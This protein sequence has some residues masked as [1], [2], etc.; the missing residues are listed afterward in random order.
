MHATFLQ[1]VG[2]TIIAAL[3]AAG[4]VECWKFT[5]RANDEINSPNSWQQGGSHF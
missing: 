4:L 3:F 5:L 1:K 2:I